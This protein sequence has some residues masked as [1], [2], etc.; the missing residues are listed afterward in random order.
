MSDF[1]IIFV[2][3]YTSSSHQNW[4]PPLTEKLREL[5]VDYV[6]PDMPGDRQPHSKEWLEIIHAEV[7]K[8]DK[9]VVLVGHSLGTRAVLLYLDQ[10]KHPAEAVI[11]VAPFA[12][13]VSNA[14]RRSG[15]AYP[16]FFEYAVDIAAIRQLSPVFVVIHSI[17]DDHIDYGQG[18]EI[19]EQLG[20]RL[21]TEHDRKHMSNP[22]NTETILNVLR[23]TLKF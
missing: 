17:D 6:V 4:Y 14:D 21:I 2:H 7:V 16:D 8:A 10:Y 12:N 13:W 23:E 3:G 1:K 9:P 15:T 5:G 18:V 22:N 19:A 20:A 11:L